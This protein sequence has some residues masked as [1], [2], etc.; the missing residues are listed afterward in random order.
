MSK[1]GKVI[2]LNPNG[3]KDPNKLNV[4][5]EDVNYDGLYFLGAKKGEGKYQFLHKNKNGYEIR[6]GVNDNILVL[7]EENEESD[8]FFAKLPETRYK[9]LKKYM[10]KDIL[11]ANKRNTNGKKG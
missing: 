6:N 5:E 11:K 8:I 9:D 1:D 4:K 3:S 7:K 10:V 2:Q